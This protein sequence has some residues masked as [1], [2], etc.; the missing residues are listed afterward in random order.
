MH[1][2]DKETSG[3]I[4]VAKTQEAFLFF[5]NQF[6]NHSVEKVYN[7]VVWGMFKEKEGI[8]NKTHRQKRQRF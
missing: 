5:K 1:R 8:I 7:A 3:V 6:K 4:L 2:L